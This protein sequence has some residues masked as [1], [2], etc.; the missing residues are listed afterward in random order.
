MSKELKNA[1][2]QY[3]GALE[4][5]LRSVLNA[6]P[7]SPDTFYGMMHYHMGWVDERLQPFQVS[8]GKQIRPLLCLL[9]CTASGGR[10]QQALPAAAAIELLHNFSLIHDDIEDASD[11]RRGRTTLWKIWGIE[12]AI[13]SGDSMFAIAHLAMNRLIE[14]QVE[15]ATVVSALRRFDETC[16]HLTQGQ[17]ADMSFETRQQVS[18][19]DYLAM[20]TGKTAILLS[21]CAELGALIGGADAHKTAHFAAFGLQLGLAFQVQDDILGIWGDESVTG[22]SAATDVTTRKKTLPILYG[23]EKSESLRKLYALPENS[24][25]FVRQ[26]VAILDSCGAKTY[27]S[28]AALAYSESA[29]SHLEAARPTGEAG[30]ALR[31]LADMLLRRNS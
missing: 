28:E 30:E 24:E 31:Q 2:E 19:D 29:L 25:D 5:E 20:I 7:G 1:S 9:C 4:Q 14:R 8:S 13:N 12:Q 17:H 10:W 21:L 16:V 15:A 18:V 23:L 3:L 11:T 26:V 27:A 22:K 6:G